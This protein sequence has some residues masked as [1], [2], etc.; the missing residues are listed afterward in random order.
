MKHEVQQVIMNIS[1]DDRLLILH[2][3]TQD[4]EFLSRQ[5]LMDYSLLLGI[6]KVH[7]RDTNVK[8]TEIGRIQSD[9]PDFS[10]VRNTR[11]PSTTSFKH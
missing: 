6:E 11:L 9:D 2:I 7:K 3:L 1:Q 4:I 10:D 8:D 5:G